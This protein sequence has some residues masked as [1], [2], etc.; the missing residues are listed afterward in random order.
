MISLGQARTEYEAKDLVKRVKANIRFKIK[1]NK[2]KVS[3]GSFKI[4]VEKE[5]KD[6]F[7]NK[8]MFPYYLYVKTPSTKYNWMFLA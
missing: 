2:L 6:P 7:G 5:S 3:P 1:Y 8:N 4:V